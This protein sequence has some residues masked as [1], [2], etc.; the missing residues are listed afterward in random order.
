MQGDMGGDELKGRWSV[1]ST[2]ARVGVGRLLPVYYGSTKGGVRGIFFLG[3]Q[4]A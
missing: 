4:R 3:K 2:R 1:V